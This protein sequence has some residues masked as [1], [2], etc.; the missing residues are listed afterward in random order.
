MKINENQRKSMKND[1]NQWKSM[2]IRGPPCH[3]ANRGPGG[4]VAGGEAL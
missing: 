1:E 2:K 3:L 4:P